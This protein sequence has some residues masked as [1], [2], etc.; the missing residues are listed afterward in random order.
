V[1]MASRLG[2]SMGAMGT[3]REKRP[4]EPNVQP[5]RAGAALALSRRSTTPTR[6]D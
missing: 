2:V 3:H 1:P 4:A 5:S 6:I